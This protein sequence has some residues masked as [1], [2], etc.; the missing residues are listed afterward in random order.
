M[1]LIGGNGGKCIGEYSS[2]KC[3]DGGPAIKINGGIINILATASLKGGNG[4]N[5]INGDET[6]IELQLGNIKG[7][8]GSGGAGGCNEPPCKDGENGKDIV[9]EKII[10]KE[11]LE[12]I[13]DEGNI[14]GNISKEVYN[15][16]TKGENEKEEEG[17]IDKSEDIYEILRD[18]II[19][20]EEE[21]TG[22]EVY[23][24]ENLKDHL[25]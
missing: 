13:N 19:I 21:E 8:V 18:D 5:L 16:V 20:N 1:Y 12:E 24:K 11:D 7:I 3:G 25:F 9:G 10:V 6:S 4:G 17:I 15:D 2:G 23:K 22:L 14:E